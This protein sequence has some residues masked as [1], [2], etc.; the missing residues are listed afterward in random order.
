MLDI[1]GA[2]GGEIVDLI[3]CEATKGWQPVILPI[4]LNCHI[5]IGNRLIL[6]NGRTQYEQ[7]GQ[8]GFRYIVLVFRNCSSKL[9]VKTQ[10]RSLLYPM[11]VKA[12]FYSSSQK[13]NNIY[14]MSVLTQKNCML[15]AYVDCPWREQ[16]QWWGD[17]R[18]QAKNTFILSSDAKLLARGIRQIAAQRVPNGLTYGHVPTAA[19]GCVL[20]DFTLTWILTFWD[21]YWQTQ[22]L[23]LFRQ[24]KGKVHEALAYFNRQMDNDKALLPYDERYWL[25]LDWSEI[26]KEGYPTL[27]NLWYIMALRVTVELFKLINDNES[28]SIYSKR[29]GK[30]TQS[31]KKSLFDVKNKTILAGLTKAGHPVKRNIPHNYAIAIL[32]DI[33]PKNN[34][35]YAQKGVL[36]VLTATHSTKSFPSP[37]FIHYVFEAAEKMGMYSQ[38]LDCLEK[39]WG[40]MLDRGLTT[41]EENWNAKPGHWSL[42]HAWSAHP[43]VHFSEI[44]LGIRQAAPGWKKVIF[45]PFFS[46]QKFVNGRVSTPLGTIKSSW[47]KTDQDVK[48]SLD[49]PAKMTCLVDIRGY[50]PITIKGR[51]HQWIIKHGT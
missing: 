27:Y 30:L 4:T 38:V 3:A 39:Y 6:K 8:W 22:D 40:N 17:A 50:K 44:L 5:A 2:K 29:L 49:I 37:Y 41:T 7:F 14:E 10:L 31:V 26:F 20:P 42:C 34:N 33:F 19:H 35:V 28:V 25:F 46:K 16:A 15:D 9:N 36:P 18:I 24:M 47:Q 21:Y 51:K 45:K 48:V 13:L 12:A 11:D 32:L 43:I 1:R 23:S